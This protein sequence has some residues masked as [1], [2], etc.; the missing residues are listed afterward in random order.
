MKTMTATIGI[1]CIL[2]SSVTQ[3]AW[4]GGPD[5]LNLGV[6]VKTENSIYKTV[7][8]ETQAMPLINFQR[9]GFYWEGSD[10]GYRVIENRN[11]E[12]GPVISLF[13][14]YGLG[15]A[16]GDVNQ[17][18]WPDIYVANDYIS[19]D[20]LYINQQDGTFKNEIADRTKLQ[21]KFSM[22]VSISDF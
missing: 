9:N 17:D 12:I 2:G 3:F 6:G 7:K 20:L 1:A 22:G 13:E 15:V 11:L 8:D 10:L 21:S 14:G 19:N 18:G 16:I 5:R 4:A